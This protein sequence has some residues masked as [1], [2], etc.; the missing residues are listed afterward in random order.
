MVSGYAERPS[1]SVE[2]VD[3][4]GEARPCEPLPDL[5][6]PVNVPAAVTAGGRLLVCGGRD[7]RQDRRGIKIG[8]FRKRRWGLKTESTT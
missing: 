5:P 6:V 8:G 7:V 2:A 1:R 3:L 4:S